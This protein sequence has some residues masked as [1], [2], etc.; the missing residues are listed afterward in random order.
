MSYELTAE[1][2]RLL[3]VFGAAGSRGLIAEQACAIADADWR[4]KEELLEVMRTKGLLE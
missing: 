2:Q 3:Q 1:Q 4:T